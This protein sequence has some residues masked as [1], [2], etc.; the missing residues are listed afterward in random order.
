MERPTG[1]V[2]DGAL[3]MFDE[4]A[5]R[6]GFRQ[7]RLNTKVPVVLRE[8]FAEIAVTC[9]VVA[10]IFGGDVDKTSLVDVHPELTHLAG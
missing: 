1:Y 3:R 5:G 6:T 7:T 10:H 2:T 4:G 9:N 8:K